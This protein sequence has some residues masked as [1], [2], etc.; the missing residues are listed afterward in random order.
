[1]TPY[2]SYDASHPKSIGY[3]LLIDDACSAFE[4]AFKR[5]NNARIE[6]FIQSAEPDNRLHLL[7]E[8]I[9]T[10][11]EC[12]Q[13]IGDDP[14][15]EEYLARFPADTATIKT[16]FAA[17]LLKPGDR[18]GKYVIVRQV[19]S[20][21]MGV[22]YQA[23]DELVGRT[24]ALKMLSPRLTASESARERL[25]AEARAVGQLSHPNVVILFDAGTEQGIGYL[26]MEYVAGGSAAVQLKNKGKFAWRDAVSIMA[27]VCRGLV[28]AHGAGLVHLDIKPGNILLSKI[29]DDH[30]MT[31]V[32]AKV[33]DFGLARHTTNDDEDEYI[34]GTP[35]YMA[36]EQMADFPTDARADIYGVGATLY[37]LLTGK[38]PTSLVERK[39]NSPIP[40]PSEQD[41]TIPAS[42]SQIVKRALQPSP[43]NRF[44]SISEM[45]TALEAALSKR[46][47]MVPW[48]RALVTLIVLLG[49]GIIIWRF[50][51]PNEQ[52]ASNA[53][54]DPTPSDLQKTESS[55]PLVVGPWESL[56]DGN[57]L[58]GWE[59]HA[60][61]VELL[62][63][64]AP[65]NVHDFSVETVD[66]QAA[67]R[68]SPTD[69]WYLTTTRQFENYQL[70]L[71][72]RWGKDTR[73]N[74]KRESDRPNSGIMYHYMSKKIDDT[75]SMS[76]AQE[77]DLWP[78]LVGRLHTLVD[79]SL[80][81]E[82]EDLRNYEK[83][84]PAW[85]QVDL[86][87]F[88]N[89]AVHVIN[90]H[91]TLTYRDAQIN[92][93]GKNSVPYTKGA[94]QLQGLTGEIYFRNIQIRSIS[95][96]ANSLY[97]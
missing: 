32:V 15:L 80:S 18:V 95:K 75:S 11:R 60:P 19:G 68:C 61:I 94:I 77:L 9:R 46:A 12:R 69:L 36:P 51:S 93:N 82:F 65:G 76:R 35:K 42:V 29:P 66:G 54:N 81:R 40:D 26:V 63:L 71:E 7:T 73:K 34:G 84:S 49:C 44:Q 67:I 8:L 37:A 5:D 50:N 17:S 24:V 23:T 20:G 28:A 62:E 43:E 39:A 56:F 45:L 1:M 57:S 53:K 47:P 14:K 33:T 31:G 59:I 16:I 22:V 6:A 97:E 4:T 25:F 96:I 3:R 83:P 89:Q 2:Y 74:A 88:R 86:L 41:P 78:P 55:Q 21:G 58:E 38:P 30:S 87:C 64:K 85:N 48:V 90:G 13:S 27:D 79:V 10:E 72:Y 70:R 92:I 52:T 91:V